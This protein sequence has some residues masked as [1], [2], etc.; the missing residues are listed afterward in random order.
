MEL[1]K[2]H[3]DNLEHE[4]M[5]LRVRLA[6]IQSARPTP[7]NSVPTTPR[8]AEGSDEPMHSVPDASP[9]PT[10]EEIL[11]PVHNM[12]IPTSVV[13]RSAMPQTTLILAHEAA[14]EWIRT[15]PPNNMG[16]EKT[17]DYYKRYYSCSPSR[18]H[19][20]KK[21]AFGDIMHDMG[22][23]TRKRGIGNHKRITVWVSV[24]CM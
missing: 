17:I 8:R 9:E 20:L 13:H 19:T 7:M 16:Y 15:N 2:L 11:R 23:I 18:V 4:N 3:R 1:I 22:Y 10:F 6:E 24:E 5:K 14:V 12:R 21:N